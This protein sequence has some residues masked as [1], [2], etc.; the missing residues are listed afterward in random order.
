MHS[1]GYTKYDTVC[2]VMATIGRFTE[3]MQPRVLLRRNSDVIKFQTTPINKSI[4]KV[5]LVATFWSFDRSG[6]DLVGSNESCNTV[7]FILKNGH[8]FL[9]SVSITKKIS[10]STASMLMMSDNI[11][12]CP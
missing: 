5:L 1:K 12:T 4:K 6:N 7:T 8:A 2:R 11:V 3:M 10:P 9:T